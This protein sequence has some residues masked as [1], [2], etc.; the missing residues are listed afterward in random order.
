MPAN[1]PIL[2]KSANKWDAGRLVIS[3][4]A[5]CMGIICGMLKFRAAEFVGD[6]NLRFLICLKD[7]SNV[8]HV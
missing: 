4:A 2:P 1:W 8:S 3:Y 5:C 6:I 7:I